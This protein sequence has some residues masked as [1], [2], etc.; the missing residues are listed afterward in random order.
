MPHAYN[1]LYLEDAMDCLGELCDFVVNRVKMS[2]ADFMHLFE[3]S[4]YARRFERGCPDVIA[5]LSGTELAVT[6]FSSCGMEME[7]P[8]ARKGFY[9]TREYTCGAALALYQWKTSVPFHSL[10]ERISFGTLLDVYE[11]LPERTDVT[12]FSHLLAGR[13]PAVEPG[14][15]LQALRKAAGLTQRELADGAGISV[16]TVQEYEQGFKNLLH[17]N[18]ETLRHL[19]IILQCPLESLLT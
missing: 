11:A 6:V 9:N 7:L 19:S 3:A 17:A 18:G 1:R 4:G 16:R 12:L 15:K 14:K 5:G 8:G 2:F 13:V 10:F